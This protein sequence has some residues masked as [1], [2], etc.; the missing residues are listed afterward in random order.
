MKES[1]LLIPLFRAFR[2]GMTNQIL[3]AMEAFVPDIIFISAGFDGH[4]DDIIGGMAAIKNTHV[5]AGYTEEDYVWA[6]ERVLEMAHRLCSGR[7]VSV[8]EGGYDIRQETN[9]LAKSIEAHIDAMVVGYTEPASEEN[10]EENDALENNE[11]KEDQVM[12]SSPIPTPSS[13][14]N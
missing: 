8:L 10:E 5:P 13:S 11:K 2:Q 7:V 14:I 9:S 12:V 1:Y 4:K 6:T 3:P